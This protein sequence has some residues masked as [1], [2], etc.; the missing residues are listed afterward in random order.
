MR[1]RWLGLALIGVLAVFALLVATT[2]SAPPP[3]E[4]AVSAAVA[5]RLE[6][7]LPL[8]DELGVTSWRDDHRGCH[9]VTFTDGVRRQDPPGSCGDSAPFDERARTAWDRIAAAAAGTVPGGRLRS[10]DE[11]DGASDAFDPALGPARQVYFE[12]TPRT[13]LGQDTLFARWLWTWDERAAGPGSDGLPAHWR[14]LA[15][16]EAL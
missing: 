16:D 11:I 4:Q 3:P 9:Y 10:I 1:K 13:L 6:A 2:L 14:F 15:Y 5:G 12:A 7:V 8:L